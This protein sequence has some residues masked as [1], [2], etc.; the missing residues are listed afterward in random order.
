MV[1]GMGGPKEILLDPTQR[2][3]ANTLHR[4]WEDACES[5]YRQSAISLVASN[6]VVEL[7]G[8]P[9]GKSSFSSHPAEPDPACEMFLLGEGSPTLRNRSF[10]SGWTAIGFE[11]LVVKNAAKVAL[12]DHF[13][14]NWHNT[15]PAIKKKLFHD[16]GEL[17]KSLAR[18]LQKTAIGFEGSVVVGRV[19]LARPTLAILNNIEDMETQSGTGRNDY[20]HDRFRL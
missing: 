20:K 15:E 1:V 5:R 7:S 9:A 10:R 12:L 11:S 19:D 8:R 3:F 14:Q 2:L 17:L 4:H 18:K 6:V 13:R 16:V